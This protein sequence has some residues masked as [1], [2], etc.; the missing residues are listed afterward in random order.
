MLVR[1][2]GFVIDV[3]RHND[4]HNV[5]TLYTRTRGRMAFLVPVGKSKQ[6]KARNAV[7]TNMACLA[8]DVNLRGGKELCHLSSPAADR[9]WHGIYFNPVKN[10]LLFF[11]TDFLN[12]LLRQSPPDAALW[13]F[14][15]SS[16]ETLDTLPTS[17]IANFHIAFLT[18]L[19]PFLGIS[20]S[21][22]RDVPG[23]GDD[24][25]K[26]FDMLSGT[27]VDPLLPEA[28]QR[29]MLLPPRESAFVTLLAR[30]SYSNMHRFRLDAA[31]RRETIDGLLR[32]Y[33]LHL[34]LPSSLPSLSI[35]HDLFK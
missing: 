24:T 34:P 13:D 11:L 3:V 6:G 15:Y 29:R 4:R 8:A 1:I 18:R 27:M 30:I 32:Y 14:I 12:R 22:D 25:L 16:L 5:V 19:L 21:L 2:R 28:P 26:L 7:I 20:P 31:G 23:K 33:S 17:R 10:S 35:L 9:L